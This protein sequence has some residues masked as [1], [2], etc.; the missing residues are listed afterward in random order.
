L[1]TEQ[2]IR[3]GFSQGNII[4]VAAIARPSISMPF[5]AIPTVLRKIEEASPTLEHFA[6]G[7]AEL[8][9]TRKLR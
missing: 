4:L 3:P 9:G 8:A 5:P 6:H 1:V 7:F 2:G